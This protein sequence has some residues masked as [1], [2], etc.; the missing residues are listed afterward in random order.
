VWVASAFTISIW[1]YERRAIRKA[2]RE[3]PPVGPPTLAHA[4]HVFR[5]SKDAPT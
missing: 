2:G 1:A 4:S 3:T 5:V